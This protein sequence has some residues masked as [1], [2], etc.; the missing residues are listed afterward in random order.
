MLVKRRYWTPWLCGALSFEKD[1]LER[2]RYQLTEL[3]ELHCDLQQGKD[4]RGPCAPA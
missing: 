2:L 4:A 1:E 3:Q